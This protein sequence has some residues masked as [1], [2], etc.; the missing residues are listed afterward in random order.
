[1]TQSGSIMM[2]NIY[3]STFVHCS[4][5]SKSVLTFRADGDRVITDSVGESVRQH[6]LANEP[7]EF[8]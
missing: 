1:M 4:P 5:L 3:L 6:A 8:G 7:V 2:S